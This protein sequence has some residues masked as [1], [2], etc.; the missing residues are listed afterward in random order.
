[1]TTDGV[2]GPT[3]VPIGIN[4]ENAEIFFRFLY[5][6]LRP[7]DGWLSLIFLS[8]NLVVVVLSVEQADWVPTPSLPG[9]LLL[10]MLT[11]LLLYR[12]PVWPGITFVLGLAVGLVVVLWQMSSYQIDGQAIGGLDALRD[13][14]ELWLNATRAGSINIDKVPFAFGLMI[15]S[16]LTGFLGAWLF[17]RHRNFWGVFLLGGFG[18]FANLTFLPPNTSFFLALYLFTAL[19]LV[20]RIQAARRRNEWQRRNVTFDDHLGSLTLSD[21]FFLTVAVVIVAFLLPVGGRWGTATDAYESM[22][23]PLATWEDDFNRLFAGLPARRPVGFRIWDDVMAF[24][25]SINPTTQQV[26]RV[27]SPLDLYW[28]A[29]TYNTYSGKGWI[30][31]NTIFE[32]LGYAPVFTTP[33]LEQERIEVTYTV[34]P[35]YSSRSLFSG[36]RVVQVGRE[37]EIETQA[38]PTYEVDL[39]AANGTGGLPG[40]LEE[41]GRDLRNAVVENGG[42]MEDQELAD[43][44]PPGFLLDEVKRDDGLVQE[45]RLMEALPSP[46]DVLSVRRPGGKFGAGEPYLV[47]S[48]VSFASPGQLRR[49]GT[50]YPTYVLDQY[51]GLPSSVTDRVRALAAELTA[52]QETPYDKAKAIEDHLRTLPYTLDFEPPAF[53]ADGVDH[54][55]FNQGKGYSEYFASSMAVMLRSVGVPTRLAVGYTS[56]DEFE[57]GIFAVTDSHSH[58]WVEVYMPGFSWV[59]FEPTPGK[60]LPAVYLEGVAS[61]DQDQFPELTGSVVEPDCLDAF[62][63]GC[64]EF[65]IPLLEN[66]PAES[67]GGGIVSSAKDLLPWILI[68]LAVLGVAGVGGYWFWNRYLA[69]SYQPRVVFA[70]MIG[71]ARLSAVGPDPYQTP[72]Q[73]GARLGYALP[74]RGHQVD[75]VVDSY[76]RSRY[77]QKEL[78]EQEEGRLADAWSR[79]RYPLLRRTFLR[80]GL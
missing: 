61:I 37:V 33:E 4:S 18:L 80:R 22:R 76:V 65:E 67:G 75:V 64:E 63:E 49:S 58:A 59:P 43:L 31:E 44:V 46:P 51:T 28:K 57:P 50:D 30:S 35:F 11:A 21:S 6:K 72:Y 69:L 13:R 14:L 38:L 27:E 45:V 17:L 8:I 60:R 23:T 66:A 55:L 26:L 32:P 36:D 5:R 79:V 47:T 48:A 9:V 56:G 41:A 15:A 70:R 25:G 74:G 53:D 20:A 24:Q 39:S 73:F 29:R 71:L 77:G 78:S 40:V 42:A 52:G 10:A 1:M 34:T 16:W 68:I 7:S 2:A 3:P 62:L 12:V 19:L 54:F